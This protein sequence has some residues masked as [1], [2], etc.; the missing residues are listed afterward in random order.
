MDNFTEL[1]LHALLMETLLKENYLAPTPIQSIAIPKIKAGKDLQASAQTG[2]GKTAA[3]L[4]PA[5]HRLLNDL[6]GNNRHPRVLILAPTRELAAQIYEQVRKFSRNLPKIKSACIVGGE[7]Y[8][9]QY[10]DLGRPLD[11][12]VA[13][14]GRLIDHLERKRVNLGNVEMLVLDE[15]DRMVD[16]GFFEPVKQIAE[17]TSADRQT[18][19]FSAT[20]KK[21]VIRLSQCLLNNPE[22]IC[23]T[24]Q[25][26]KHSQIDERLHFTDNQDH[27]KELL[28]HFLADPTL[29]HA[30]IFTA[31][32]RAADD[33]ADQ[34]KDQGHKAAA[35]H[36]DMQQRART[37][38]IERLKKGE[39]RILVATDVAAR[40][41]DIKTISHVFNFDLPQCAE[42]Y[43]HRIGRTGRSGAT[44]VAVSFASARDLSNVR[45]IEE[46]T[47]HKLIAT[48]VAGME[49]KT[50]MTASRGKRG[51]GRGSFAEKRRGFSSNRSE[52]RSDFKPRSR[53]KSNSKPGE[54]SFSK[55]RG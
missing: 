11:I 53:P 13:T 7:P 17:A 19:L 24:P 4:L 16:L 22:E 21:A 26:E 54:R 35:L 25:H 38:T 52:S 44:G 41:I 32:K 43:V 20:M 50:S 10:K 9:K 48:T 30:I 6:T 34:L 55:S 5:L 18:L 15:A 45:D 12:L 23:I 27:K 42:D 1:E 28:Q 46:F 47:G 14:P 2:T 49:P 37:R 31:T 29:D 40:G 36:G 8:P 39:I 51:V 3:F 33:L